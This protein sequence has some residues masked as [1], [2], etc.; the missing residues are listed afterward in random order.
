MDPREPHTH[1][2]DLK[3]DTDVLEDFFADAEPTKDATA[4]TTSPIPVLP[5]LGLSLGILVA[6]FGVTFISLND[7]PSEETDVRVT[8]RPTEIVHEEPSDPFEDVT[9][10]AKAA[11]VWDV[12]GK[13]MLFNKNGDA[14]LPLASI[15]KLMTALVA[16]ELL[17]PEDRIT[18]SMYDLKAE[19]DSGLMNG[20]RFSMQDLLDLTLI[21]S[22]NDG[23]V[24]LGANAASAIDDSR[25]PEAL[26]TA[27]MNVKAKELGLERT[28]FKNSTGL[29]LSPTEAG[30]FGSAEDVVILMEHI[31]LN[32]PDAVALTSL[33]DA[34][35]LNESGEYHV[36]EN[37]N[38]IT[39]RINGLIASKTG[40][41][42]I[43]GGNLV[44]AYNAGLDRPIIISVLGS[45]PSRRFTDTL[46]LV[47]RTK[48]YL[49]E[50]N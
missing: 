10:A 41:T 31:I 23:A 35:I 18:I 43:A 15:T 7:A 1:E 25:D 30:A 16:Y 26:F 39:N 4:Q 44:I 47:E 21:T 2:H 37:T 42:D 48:R 22:S 49:T 46:E 36:A 24:A 28:H 50:T 14:S 33:A 45:T 27:A 34:R 3:H 8:E 20:E 13:R 40:T 5:E 6:V 17:D 19:G 29:D 32:I 9:I 38:E 11:V 12:K